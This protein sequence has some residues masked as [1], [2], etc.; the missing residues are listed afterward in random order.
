MSVLNLSILCT[1]IPSCSL[2]NVLDNDDT[3]RLIRAIYC[4]FFNVSND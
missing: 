4:D 1:N 3:T 2:S